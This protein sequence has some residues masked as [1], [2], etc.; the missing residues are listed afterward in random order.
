MS[1]DG[2]KK[3]AIGAAVGVV[4]GFLA[5]ILTAP[6]SGKETRRDIKNTANKVTRETEKK[7]K[8][9]YTDLGQ[10]INEAKALTKREGAKV[11]EELL[12]ALHAAE[13]TQQK[14]KEVITAIR[15]GEADRPELDKAVKEATAA[16][17][18]LKKFLSK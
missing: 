15:D 5:G 17:E 16:K 1:K 12:K 6:K 14:V 7:L 4:T 10:T 8:K 13:K 18:H 2:N 11:K 9:L 3:L